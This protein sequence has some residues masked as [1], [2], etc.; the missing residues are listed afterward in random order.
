MLYTVTEVTVYFV[1]YEQFSTNQKFL[2]GSGFFG[3]SC[4]GGKIDI[5][6]NLGNQCDLIL[7]E[8]RN[9][10]NTAVKALV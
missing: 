5:M 2:N 3:K 6:E 8:I 1:L 7:D 4:N 10:Y 9:L